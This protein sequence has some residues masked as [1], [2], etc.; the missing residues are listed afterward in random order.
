VNPTILVLGGGGMLGHKMFQRLRR[1]FPSTFCALHRRATDQP[2]SSIPM[3]QGREVFGE[4]DALD[5]DRLQ[6]LMNELR[7][8]VVV[9][10]VGVIKQ[11]KAA[12]D[13][14]VLTIRVNSVLPHELA[15][16]TA[17]WGG[18]VV[19]FSTDCVFSGRRG[20]YSEDDV[21]DAE[22]LYGRSKFLGELAAPNTLTL[23]TSIIGR[24]LTQHQSLLD[25]F[26]GQN[27]KEVTGFS[28]AIY[29]G[30]TTNHLSDLV[31][32]LIGNGLP[33][34]GLYQVA[35][36]KISKHDLLAR[37]RDT[38]RLDIGLT[39]DSSFVCDRS[40]TVTKLAKA[41]G[42]RCPPWDALIAE[43]ASD[44]TPYEEWL[45]YETV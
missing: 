26:L 35:S 11:R 23:R 7:P 32:A 39:S 45:H 43:L 38:F 18:R 37:I 14:A 22:D 16:I 13:D 21:S 34:S 33:I 10:C 41:I 25:W 24:E 17:R 19:H 20:N 1:D 28:R 6:R 3:F 15:A 2:Y 36:E 44:P 27:H 8:D 40:L 31:A 30:V 12:K 4:I 29:S 42:Y 9:N 5:T